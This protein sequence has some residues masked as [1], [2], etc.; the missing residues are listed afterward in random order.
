[1]NFNFKGKISVKIKRKIHLVRIWSLELLVQPDL[2]IDFKHTAMLSQ[3]QNP[4]SECD[5]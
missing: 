5:V 2:S 1:M 3:E 4:L